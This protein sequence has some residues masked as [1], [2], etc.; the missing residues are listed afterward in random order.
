MQT[1]N[2]RVSCGG[3]SFH[4]VSSLHVIHTHYTVSQSWD[5]LN[6]RFSQNIGCDTWDCR[7]CASEREGIANRK[8]E[9]G[10]AFNMRNQGTHQCGCLKILM[11]SIYMEGI[12]RFR[13]KV[14]V[15]KDVD[16][17]THEKQKWKWFLSV[18]IYYYTC[19]LLLKGLL[20]AP[21]YWSP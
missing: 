18:L 6:I 15:C 10:W 17:R 4:S 7:V 13:E 1:W 5:L 21:G 14:C 12:A 8:W 11:Q 20:A 2:Q 3:I 9:C 16:E 19:Y